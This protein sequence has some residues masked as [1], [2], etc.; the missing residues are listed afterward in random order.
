MR[1]IFSILLLTGAAANCEGLEGCAASSPALLQRQRKKFMIGGDPTTLY[2]NTDGTANVKGIF[3]VSYDP[4]VYTSGTAAENA[5][6]QEKAWKAIKEGLS[7]LLGHGVNEEEITLQWRAGEA[8]L[9]S[10]GRREDVE[11]SCLFTFL[12][13]KSYVAFSPFCVPDSF[14]IISAGTVAGAPATATTSTPGIPTTQTTSPGG[15]A[16][17]KGIFE[18]SYDPSVYT[19][20]TAAENAELQEKAWKAIKEGLSVLLGLQAFLSCLCCFLS[21]LV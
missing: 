14:H 19:S 2:G 4:S 9:Q 3:E 10:E 12:C 20:G 17:V 6:L 5:E 7:V 11:L 15:T 16:N 21:L 1:G 13:A 8:L 18:V